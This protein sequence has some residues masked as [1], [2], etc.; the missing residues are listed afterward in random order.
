MRLLSYATSAA[1]AQYAHP[2]RRQSGVSEIGLLSVALIRF[3][4]IAAD[5]HLNWGRV[6]QVLKQRDRGVANVSG[7]SGSACRISLRSEGRVIAERRL[8]NVTE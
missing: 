7:I 5:G 1:V 8:S 3:A 4:C 2:F 6:V